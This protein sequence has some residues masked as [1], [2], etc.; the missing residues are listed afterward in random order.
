MMNNFYMNYE[1]MVTAEDMELAIKVTP[2]MDE[3]IRDE[4]NEFSELFEVDPVSA[5]QKLY[6]LLR[7]SFSIKK[8]RAI[9]AYLMQC[10]VVT[11]KWEEDR[12]IY[13]PDEEDVACALA[14]IRKEGRKMRDW[15]LHVV[16]ADAPGFD[17]DNDCTYDVQNVRI[18][19]K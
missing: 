11:G 4:K 9:A 5:F 6:P 12:N 2:I 3:V 17:P 19:N 8:K 1:A 18:Y 7:R 10:M 15:C 14:Y 16:N 13:L